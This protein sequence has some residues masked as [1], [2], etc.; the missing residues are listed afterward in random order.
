MI[1]KIPGRRSRVSHVV[2]AKA[3]G[4][5]LQAPCTAREIAQ[6]TGL[7]Q[8]TTYEL[9]R[10]MS[11]YQAAHISAWREDSLGRESIAVFSLGRGEDAAR[12]TVR[13]R[14]GAQC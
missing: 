4:L 9:L 1:K 5:L 13:R 2:L 7:H 14:S 10:A 6:E 8:K 11:K 12:R 3:V